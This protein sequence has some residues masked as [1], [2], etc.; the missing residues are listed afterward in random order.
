VRRSTSAEER[1]VAIRFSAFAWLV[2]F[3]FLLGFV[4][5]PDKQRILLMLP[6]FIVAVGLAKFWRDKRADLRRKSAE[7]ARLDRMKRVN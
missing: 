5:L 1:G 4:F 7:Q 6:A 2:G 3:L